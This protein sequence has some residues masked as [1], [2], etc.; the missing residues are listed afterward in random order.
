MKNSIWMLVL[1]L[2]LISCNTAKTD[3]T[4][5]ELN[6]IQFYDFD[7][8]TISVENLTK[9]WNKRIQEDEKINA[10]IERLEVIHLVDLKS[11]QKTLV[12]LGTTN[13]KSVKTAATLTEYKNG[14]KLSSLT[15][16]C[17]N[18]DSDLNVELNDN[19]WICVS[20][21]N[22]NDACTKIVSLR[23]E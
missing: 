19:N 23:T 16:T 7:D 8:A 14:L 12:L 20:A 10:Q 5:A 3:Y 13:Q 15:V 17:K 11:N 6:S 2:S 1:F 22:E 21:T 18:C 4:T 9:Q